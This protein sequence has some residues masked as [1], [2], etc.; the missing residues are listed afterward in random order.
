MTFSYKIVCSD[1]TKKHFIAI[2]APFGLDSI[3]YLKTEFTYYDSNE[4]K[5]KTEEMFFLGFIEG[6]TDREAIKHY[7]ENLEKE[8]KNG[9]FIRSLEITLFISIGSKPVAQTDIAKEPI[10]YD[11]KIEKALDCVFELSNSR[12]S[13]I[14]S[15][16]SKEYE[17]GRSIVITISHFG[18]GEVESGFYFIFNKE[19]KNSIAK[20]K[21]LKLIKEK[22]SATDRN[23]IFLKLMYLC[24]ESLGIDLKRAIKESE[25]KSF[26]L[27]ASSAALKYL[28]N[29]TVNDS[30]ISEEYFEISTEEILIFENCAVGG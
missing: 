8:L 2:S 26:F 20:L 14:R 23:E 19:I 5:T 27:Y 10:G 11:A 16:Q 25:S 15:V 4:L 18:Y 1:E 17:I 13:E 12:L 22:A 30:S 21:E 6:S 3:I 24:E 7:K 28:N 29:F 9:L